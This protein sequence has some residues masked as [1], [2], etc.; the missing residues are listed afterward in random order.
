MKRIFI[1]MAALPMFITSCQSTAD[2]PTPS[3]ATDIKILATV[4]T[5]VSRAGL[6]SENLTDFGLI[7]TNAAAPTT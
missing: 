6:T 3:G 1:A 5:P 2:E 4:Q 7:A